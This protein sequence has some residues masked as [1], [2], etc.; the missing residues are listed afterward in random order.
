M[1][2]LEGALKKALKT[3]IL[4]RNLLVLEAGA[5][6][7]VVAISNVQSTRWYLLFVCFCNTEK[8]RNILIFDNS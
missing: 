2:G 1:L 7:G 8:L 5:V 3:R 4:A 6:W